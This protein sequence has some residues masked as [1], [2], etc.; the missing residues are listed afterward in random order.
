M[1]EQTGLFWLLFVLGLLLATHHDCWAWLHEAGHFLVIR[2]F[3][4]QPNVV[5]EK[6]RVVHPYPTS[7]FG[8]LAG[9]GLVLLAL[10]TTTVVY[11]LGGKWSLAGLPWGMAHYIV[12]IAYGSS[13]LEMAGATEWWTAYSLA[14]L[15]LGWWAVARGER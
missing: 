10:F 6:Y 4:D 15:A 7:L 9:G 12:Y 8:K 13:D 14:L 5:L 2:G 11:A 1:K 3:E